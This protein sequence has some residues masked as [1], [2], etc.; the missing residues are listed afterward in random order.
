MVLDK[1]YIVHL[2]QFSFD[3]EDKYEAKFN[4]GAYRDAG[5]YSLTVKVFSDCYYG[6]DV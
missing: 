2:E 3:K 4:R 1:N 6:L 5:N